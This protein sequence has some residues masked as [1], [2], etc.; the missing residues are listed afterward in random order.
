VVFINKRLLLFK[1]RF[2]FLKKIF[3]TILLGSQKHPKHALIYIKI[4]LLIKRFYTII[5]S[6]A[7]W[8]L[9]GIYNEKEY[10]ELQ[11][12]KNL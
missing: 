1:K 12:Y 11:G 4:T 2:T 7:K 9:G 3:K 5:G 6:V 8:E 10:K